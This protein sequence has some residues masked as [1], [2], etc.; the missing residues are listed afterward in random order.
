MMVQQKKLPKEKPRDKLPRPIGDS[1]CK[2]IEDALNH[3]RKQVF[4]TI[5]PRHSIE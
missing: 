2:G 3:E 4:H 5:G 1:N